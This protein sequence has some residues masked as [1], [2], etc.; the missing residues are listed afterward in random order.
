MLALSAANFW[1]NK[2]EFCSYISSLTGSSI[3]STHNATSTFLELLSSM[4]TRSF[5]SYSFSAR[6]RATWI[7]SQNRP[8][9]VPS[10]HGSTP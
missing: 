4:I 6:E 7:R 1:L 9:I 8:Y 3:L 5:W 10:L 2:I